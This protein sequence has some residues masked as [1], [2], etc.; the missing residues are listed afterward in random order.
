M[1]GLSLFAVFVEGGS[2]FFKSRDTN[3]FSMSNIK[4]TEK[5]I[6]GVKKKKS[7][8]ITSRQYHQY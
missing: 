7:S 4:S 1:S 6:H 3:I 2:V 5:K 8:N